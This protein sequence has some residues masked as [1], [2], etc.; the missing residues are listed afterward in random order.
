MKNGEWANLFE[1]ICP[2]RGFINSAVVALYHRSAWLC[3]V[4]KA[5][6]LNNKNNAEP[7]LRMVFE[8]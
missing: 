4:D 7:R 6:F 1:L 2:R 8:K 3:Q 5:P